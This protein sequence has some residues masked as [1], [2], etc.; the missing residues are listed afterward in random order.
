[1]YIQLLYR[2][3][4]KGA[5]YIELIYDLNLSRNTQGKLTL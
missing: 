1:M 3:G 4:Y 5:Q 2:N